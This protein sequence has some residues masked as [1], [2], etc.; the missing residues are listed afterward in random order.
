MVSLTTQPNWP[1]IFRGETITLICEIQGGDTEWEYEWKTTS[2]YKPPNQ[3]E[4]RIDSAS[5]SHL[6]NYECR[7]RIKSAQQSSTEWSN[8]FS[9]TVSDSESLH[10]S[11]LV[12]G[13][14]VK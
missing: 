2:S 8:S 1:Q 6:G 12:F 4:F 14:I 3:N 11:S 7:G 9:L 10:I 13:K 5:S